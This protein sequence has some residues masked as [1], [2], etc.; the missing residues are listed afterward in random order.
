MKDLHTSATAVF[1]FLA[2]FLAGTGLNAQISNQD[3]LQLRDV[4]SLNIQDPSGLSLHSEK[5]FLWTVSDAAGG[6]ITLITESGQ[7]VSTLSYPGD[8]MEGISYDAASNSLWIAEE[9]ELELRRLS[10]QGD[11]LEIV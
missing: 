11:V 2:A 9:G 8:D 5:G 6:N 1:L 3:A 10:L 4:V 7:R